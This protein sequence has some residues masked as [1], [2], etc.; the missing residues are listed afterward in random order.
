[1]VSGAYH[2]ALSRRTETWDVVGKYLA[3]LVML[4]SILALT[5]FYA[6]LLLLF[7]DPDIGP[8]LA[9][10]LGLVLFGAATLAVGVLASSL[11]SNQ[12]VAAVISFGILLFLTLLEQ[13]ADV[14]PGTPAVLLEQLSLTGHFNDFARGVIDTNNIIY[15]LS[16]IFVTL[17]LAIRNLESKRWR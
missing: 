9:G 1:M 12:I 14:T 5:A 8:L 15:Y 16:F 2:E 7:G 13:A 10:Y 11:T 17:F 3:S 4:L 6:L